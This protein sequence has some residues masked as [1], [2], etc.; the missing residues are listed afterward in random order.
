[1]EHCKNKLQNYISIVAAMLVTVNIN[2]NTSQENQRASLSDLLNNVIS[3]MERELGKLSELMQ[4]SSAEERRE[5]TCLLPSTG[6]RPSFNITKAQIEALRETGMNWKSISEF[7]GVSE[8]TLQRRRIEYGIEPSF[9]E[10]S[11]V[12]LDNQIKDILRLTPTV[13][14]AM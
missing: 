4:M 12:D 2:N 13:V 6:G 5:V 3:G 11:N 9:N 8:R 1:M 7:L 14:N 10:I